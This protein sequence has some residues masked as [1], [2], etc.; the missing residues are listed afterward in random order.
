MWQSLCRK[1]YVGKL[2]LE[3]Q[4]SIGVMSVRM[5][6]WT[7][8]LLFLAAT[9]IGGPGRHAEGPLPLSYPPG[10]AAIRV[11]L[12]ALA[13]SLPRSS[14]FKS[15]EVFVAETEI[16]HEEWSFIKLVFTFLPYEPRLSESGFDYSVVHEVSASRDENCD[17][18]VE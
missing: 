7:R 9:C 4:A 18:T 10:K 12:V 8:T 16:A 2:I 13:I 14:F 1:A 6:N 5:K 11:R 15:S 17:Q 3:N